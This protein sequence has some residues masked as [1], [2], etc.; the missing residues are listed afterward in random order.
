[1]A[2]KIMKSLSSTLELFR[3]RVSWCDIDQD[4]VRQHLRLCLFEDTGVFSCSE[5]WK[6]DLSTFNCSIN[7]NG[8]AS[9]VARENM[10][11]SGLALIPMI[12]E[13]FR[14]EEVHAELMVKDGDVVTKETILG[15]LVG[16]VRHLLFIERTLLNFLQKLSGISTYTLKLF[17]IIEPYEVGLLDTRKT[18]PGL[19]QLEKYATACGGSFNHRMGLNDRILIK[20]NHLAAAKVESASDLFEFLKKI[21]EKNQNILIELEIDHLEYLNPAIDAE[22]DVILLDNFSPSEV[23]EA[24]SNSQGQILTEVSGGIGLE[25]LEEF[26]KTQPNF[27]STGAPTHSSRWM[28]IGLD[29]N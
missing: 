29:W 27:I 13:I 14:T 10:V 24:V 3:N 17:Q 2:R 4:F 25:N 8:K 12:L 9:I 28:D 6:Y 26:A 16:S 21:R 11:C 5:P 20:D 18:T 7:G 19:R 1:M 15:N 23:Q 22:I